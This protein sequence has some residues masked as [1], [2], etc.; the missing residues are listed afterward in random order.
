MS[1][2][3]IPTIVLVFNVV[4]EDG[5]DLFEELLER[6][7]SPILGKAA[8]IKGGIREEPLGIGLKRNLLEGLKIQTLKKDVKEKKHLK[9][10][11]EKQLKQVVEKEKKTS[12][13]R[14]NVGEQGV[15]P[16]QFPESQVD[17]GVP[18]TQEGVSETQETVPE[19]QFK[20]VPVVDVALV[21]AGNKED[22]GHVV[23]APIIHK[24]IRARRPSERILK[25]KLKNP[26]FDKDGGGSTNDNPVDLE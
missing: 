4:P 21:E 19:T 9:Q 26:V 20:Q 22:Q 23:D 17:E 1:P 25:N 6:D 24:K 13:T 11:V 3:T 8:I 12:E 18:L 7:E 10:V 2:T 15:P 14:Q 5:F 16:M